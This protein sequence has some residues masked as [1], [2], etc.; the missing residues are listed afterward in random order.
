[1][2]EDIKNSIDHLGQKMKEGFDKVQDE[3]GKVRTE[4]SEGFD[5]VQDEFGKVRTEMSDG[6]D[7]MGIMI[8]E[9]FDETYKRLDSI[10]SRLNAI[11]ADI[12]ALKM[13]MDAVEEALDKI[14]RLT[15]ID[16]RRRIEYVEQ[17]VRR[18]KQAVAL[19]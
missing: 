9:S 17:E 13:R 19:K 10:E 5:K 2:S 11:E 4:M 15:L 14:D 12:A 1:M 8:K 3:F 18:L 16:Y 6:F 7:E